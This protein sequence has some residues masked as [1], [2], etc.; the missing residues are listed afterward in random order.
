M[1]FPL[2]LP[3]HQPLWLW[4]GAVDLLQDTGHIRK[5]VG[6]PPAV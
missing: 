3:F 1:L 5:R 6:Y 2:W 4:R